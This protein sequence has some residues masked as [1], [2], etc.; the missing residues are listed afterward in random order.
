M[1][2]ASSEQLRLSLSVPTL[3]ARRQQQLSLCRLIL[4]GES[5]IPPSMFTLVSHPNPHTQDSCPL[6]FSFARTNASQST[7]F[8]DSVHHGMIYL[9]VITAPSPPSFKTF[10]SLSHL[11]H[12]VLYLLFCF[13]RYYCTD[14][15]YSLLGKSIICGVVAS[16]CAVQQFL[17]LELILFKALMTLYTVHCSPLFASFLSSHFSPCW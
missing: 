12:Y 8:I 5:V 15:Y 13:V 6:V 9:S 2:A 1:L 14:C 7:F 11:T 17:H 3:A 10:T 4:R 16:K